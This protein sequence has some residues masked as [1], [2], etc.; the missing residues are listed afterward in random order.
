MGL[1]HPP[2]P[3]TGEGP[4]GQSLLCSSAPASRPRAPIPGSGDVRTFWYR[5]LMCSSRRQPH[6]KERA[7]LSSVR[8]V[9]GEQ[10]KFVN[11]SWTLRSSTA[12]GDPLCSH[13]PPH[14]AFPDT[15]PPPTPP[16]SPPRPSPLPSFLLLLHH[17]HIREVVECS[18]RGG[19]RTGKARVLGEPVR[20]VPPVFPTAVITEPRQQTRGKLPLGLRASVSKPMIRINARGWLCPTLLEAVPAGRRAVGRTKTAVSSEEP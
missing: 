13:P 8:T 18:R 4:G 3:W 16:P 19:E 15:I 9:Q 20:C 14:P 5:T 2:P 7:R 1:N 12:P 6:S 10:V 17:K 11:R